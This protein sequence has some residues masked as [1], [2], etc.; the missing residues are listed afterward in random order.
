MISCVHL[1]LIRPGTMISNVNC[2]FLCFGGSA[3]LEQEKELVR[4]YLHKL[5]RP[6]FSRRSMYAK[7][8]PYV[9]LPPKVLIGSIPMTLEKT[10]KTECYLS[11]G[12]L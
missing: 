2:E 9:D 3:L 4:W 10:S 5:S 11:D 6:R 8:N 1:L 12:T 7:S